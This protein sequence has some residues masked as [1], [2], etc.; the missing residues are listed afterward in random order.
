VGDNSGAADGGRHAGWARYLVY[1]ERHVLRTPIV[2][3]VFVLI[4]SVLGAAGQ[5]LFKAGTDRAGD[6]PL[7]FLLSAWVWAGMACYLAVMFLFTSAFRAGGMVTVLYPIYAS[8]FIWAALMGWM[9]Y[10]Q[11]VRPIHVLGML[12]LVVGM[13]CMGV[14]NSGT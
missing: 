10:H 6:H 9:F 2:A 7:G 11:P 13:Y 3:I 12:L 1:P 5:Y 4:A 14:G 8:T